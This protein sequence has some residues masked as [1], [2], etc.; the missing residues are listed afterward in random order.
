MRMINQHFYLTGDNKMRNNCNYGCCMHCKYL[1]DDKDKKWLACS[2][3]CITSRSMIGK[4]CTICE[5]FSYNNEI[6]K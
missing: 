1:I 4:S 5:H 3:S 2:E 6:K